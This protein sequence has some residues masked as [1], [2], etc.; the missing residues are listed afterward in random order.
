MFSWNKEIEK[1]G[2]G[3]EKWR[4]LN[5]LTQWYQIYSI[6]R[7]DESQAVGSC[8]CWTPLLPHPCIPG[9]QAGS[10]KKS[11]PP[12]LVAWTSQ[13][14]LLSVR[15]TVSVHPAWPPLLCSWPLTTALICQHLA[16]LPKIG[17]LLAQLSALGHFGWREVCVTECLCTYRR[18]QG[19]HPVFI[20]AVFTIDK[21][22]NQPRCSSADCIFTQS[23]FTQT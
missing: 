17:H 9:A 7:K 2:P 12:Q 23:G 19:A 13:V 4:G 21:L 11:P 16:F 6:L 1:T 15:P 3:P 14:L 22:Q 18:A 5:F 8:P 10:W 20:V